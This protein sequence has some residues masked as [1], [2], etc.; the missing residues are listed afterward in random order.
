MRQRLIIYSDV[1][2]E[3]DELLSYKAEWAEMTERRR[4]LL[5]IVSCMIFIY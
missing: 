1:Q 2:P 4:D 3:A 5:E